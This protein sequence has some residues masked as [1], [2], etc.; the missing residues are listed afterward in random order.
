MHVPSR[1]KAKQT[2][3]VEG[4]RVVRSCIRSHRAGNAGLDR[5]LQG[6]ED[7]RVAMVAAVT[8]LMSPNGTMRGAWA[9]EQAE[10]ASCQR[11]NLIDALVG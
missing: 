6:R 5:A 7:I 4:E 3:S 11:R 2:K 1:T 9:T 10:D 8:P